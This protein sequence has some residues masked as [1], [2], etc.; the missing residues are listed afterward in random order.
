MDSCSLRTGEDGLM[1]AV[2]MGL[3]LRFTGL[4]TTSVDSE[5]LRHDLIVLES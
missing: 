2:R 1:L 4:R 5:S 3:R